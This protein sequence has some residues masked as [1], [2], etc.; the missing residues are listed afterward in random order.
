LD[1]RTAIPSPCFLAAALLV[2]AS[3]S[4]PG[5]PPHK[6]Q[7]DPAEL[8]QQIA[9]ELLASAPIILQGTVEEVRFFGKTRRASRAA[10]LLLD[11]IRVRVRIERVLKGS[12]PGVEIQIFAFRY[13][14]SNKQPPPPRLFNPQPGDHRLFYLREDAGR[15]RPLGDVRNFTTPVRGSNL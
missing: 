3:C 1:A 7:F 4:G 11:P 2:L 5:E 8:T 10:H 13:S 9:P 14:A 6:D 12:V 15:L